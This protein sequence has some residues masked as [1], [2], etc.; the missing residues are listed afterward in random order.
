[1]AYFC[2]YIWVSE[3]NK[4]QLWHF[5]LGHTYRELLMDTLVKEL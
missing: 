2:A 1:M 5:V 4:T 3:E